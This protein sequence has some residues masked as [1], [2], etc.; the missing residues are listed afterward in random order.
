MRDDEDFG[1]SLAAGCIVFVLG[2]LCTG[3]YIM[4][5]PPSNGQHV[6]YITAVSTEWDCVSVYVKTDLATTQEDVY[7][8]R[9]GDESKESLIEAMN[10]KENIELN[11]QTYT[12]GWCPYDLSSNLLQKTNEDN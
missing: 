7:R 10:S 5:R 3:I 4:V 9:K 8:M 6:G 11:Y 1:V 2:I 12:V